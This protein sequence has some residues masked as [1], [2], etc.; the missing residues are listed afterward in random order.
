MQEG[1]SYKTK[2]G[3]ASISPHSEPLAPRTFARGWFWW[4]PHCLDETQQVTNEGI[5]EKNNKILQ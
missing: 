1:L 5:L 3:T 4:R 2:T